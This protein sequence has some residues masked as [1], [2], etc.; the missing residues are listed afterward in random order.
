LIEEEELSEK[1]GFFVER[2][3]ELPEIEDD[4]EGGSY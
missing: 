2:A 4:G 3:T 1:T